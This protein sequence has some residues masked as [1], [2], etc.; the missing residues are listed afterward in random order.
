MAEEKF[1]RNYKLIVLYIVFANRKTIGGT[2]LF[3]N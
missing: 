2:T 3:D 1:E